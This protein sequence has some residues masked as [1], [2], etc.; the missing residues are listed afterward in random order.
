MVK[1]ISSR[2]GLEV[3][4]KAIERN[5]K[6]IQKTVKPAQVLA[7]L[8]ANA[9]GLGALP[10]ADRLVDLGL[11]R[12]GVAEMKEALLL[13][14]H[15]RKKGIPIPVQI[16]SGILDT[17]VSECVERGIICPISD[18]HSAKSLSKAARGLRKKAKVHIKIDSGMGRL[19]IPHFEAYELVKKI[20][21]LPNIEME[22]ILSHLANANNPQHPKTRDQIENFKILLSELRRDGIEFPLIHIANSDGINNFPEV[23]QNPFNMVR[24]GINL[25]GVF[26]L[27]G[28]RRYPLYPS[29]KLQTHLLLKRQ[30]PAGYSIGYGCSHVLFRKTWVGTIPA[31]YADGIPLAASNSAWVLVRGKRCPVIGRVSMDYVTI[32]LSACPDVKEGEPVIIVGKSGKEVLSIEDWARTKQTHPYE[33]ICSLG[34]RVE[35]SYIG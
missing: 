17:E 28:E 2:V 9:Y 25:Y 18:L 4:L 35:R 16:L 30:L 22:G 31:G 23:Y 26:D 3:N 32:D 13:S 5:F 19:G 12:I 6:R 29:L 1:K 15:F 24:T 11:D 27:E 8:K 34:S 14:G 20:S 10:I 21:K 33:I 7:A